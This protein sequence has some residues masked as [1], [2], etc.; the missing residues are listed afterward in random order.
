MKKAEVYLARVGNSKETGLIEGLKRLY[1]ELAL[2][3]EDRLV[4]VKLHFGEKGGTAFLRPIYA[5]VVVDEIRNGGGKPFLTD[6]N[7]L[8]VG[9]RSNA[10]EHMDT[11]MH[12]GFIP[13]VVDAPI[14]IADGLR[15][16]EQTSV[17]F[18]GGKHFQRALLGSAIVQAD[19]LVGLSH[20]KGHE[21][22]GFGGALKNL[23]M[24]L[25]SRAGKE[26]MHG[27]TKLQ[28]N[29]EKCI[30]CGACMANCPAGAITMEGNGK[31]GSEEEGTGEDGKMDG[32]DGKKNH[33]FIDQEKCI[34]CGEC[35]SVCPKR[36]IKG[37]RSLWG[38]SFAEL[39]EKMVE[40]A[41][42]YLQDRKD[43]AGFINFVLDVAPRCDCLPWS[44][45]CVA[46]DLGILA[47]RD[48][49]ALDQACMDL[50]VEQEG[51]DPF[52][53]VNGIDWSIQ[54]EHGEKLGLGTRSYTLKDVAPRK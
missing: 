28:V 50:L 51:R 47:S 20:F 2:P 5:G 1:R 17:E 15:G 22:T 8:Y 9:S 53:E 43:R 30:G 13:P 24:G 23:G 41:W 25:G 48:P 14:V 34:G 19:I 36:A 27:D 44:E 7:T 35:L 49:V 54:L 29:P 3:V 6:T 45:R 37:G 4:A 26:M 32:E 33:A 11:A 52:K 42:A 46:H 38:G 31:G 16:R 12:H 10:V 21:M 39:Q 18:E 40:Y